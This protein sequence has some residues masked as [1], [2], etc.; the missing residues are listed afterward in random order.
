MQIIQTKLPGVLIIE[1][2]VFP[3]G[4]GYFFET[5]QRERYIQ[6]GISNEFVQ[7]NLSYSVKNTLRGLHYQLPHSQAKLVQ[8]LSGEAL[9]VAVDIRFGSPTFGQW[10][11][12]NLSS[13]NKKQLFIPRG[14]AHGFCVL[15]ATVLFSYKCDD[16]YAPDCEKGILWSDPDIGVGWDIATPLLSEKDRRY[17]FLRDVPRESLP[18]Y[19]V[20]A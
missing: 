4:R 1:P 2:R 12:V 11:G 14:F 5:Y 3:D 16:F 7:D 6:H 13:E 18:V 8:V 19:K 17:P 9:D 10:I 15:S 20:E